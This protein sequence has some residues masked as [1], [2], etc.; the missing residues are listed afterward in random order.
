[1]IDTSRLRRLIDR[2]QPRAQPTHRPALVPLRM[3]G[4]EIGHATPEVARR[5]AADCQGFA[6]D[7]GTL[8]VHGEGE[9]FEERSAF[10]AGVSLFLR[11]TGLLRGWRNELLAVRAGAGP[12]AIAAIE[13][14]ACRPL[15]ITTSAVHLNA[16]ADHQTLIVAR[17]A[18][19]KQ[20]DP[21]KWDNLVGG[22]VPAG[23]T[24]AQALE[25]E[26]HEE[27]GISL[28]G[29][30]LQAGRKL[31]IHREVAEGFQSEIIH[32]FDATLDASRKIRNQDGEVALFEW[33]SIADVVEAIEREQFTLE[34]ALVTLETLTRRTGDQTPD[35][36]YVA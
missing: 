6:L 30:P 32:I 26:A 18:A 16:F 27:A 22:M 9:T 15:G 14:A 19:H 29:I 13:R 8:I 33:R 11:D 35:G 4:A 3:A 25:R 1:V 17:R 34:A 10:L 5:L 28:A 2:L 24:I 36:L 7:S 20:I 23:E 31:H 12:A 21:G